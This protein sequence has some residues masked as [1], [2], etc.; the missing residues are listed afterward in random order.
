MDIPVS[1]ALFDDDDLSAV[2][3]HLEPLQ[4]DRIQTYAA[5][6]EVNFDQCLRYLINVAFND[7]E[8]RQRDTE[9]EAES[10]R[11]QDEGT[12]FGAFRQVAQRLKRLEEQRSSVEEKDAVDLIKER[13]SQ[14][15][16]MMKEE[17][18]K[19]QGAESQEA[20]G[21]DTKEKKTNGQGSGAQ[22]ESPPSM[23]DIADQL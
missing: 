21:K 4:V 18:A 10:A 22:D 17:R 12:V 3:V 20:K 2:K 11:E 16:K 19:S 7:L 14:H 15:H 6:R 13:F 5:Q 9:G 8:E 23:F 1:D